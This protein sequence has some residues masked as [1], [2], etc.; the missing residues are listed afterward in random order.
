[1]EVEVDKVGASND[2]LKELVLRSKK[3]TKM[4]VWRRAIVDWILNNG[5]LRMVGIG[6]WSDKYSNQNA[7][8]NYILRSWY[9]LHLL[10]MF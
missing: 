5:R 2:G 1:M 9:W 8:N 4:V 6:V 3:N 7:N 10:L